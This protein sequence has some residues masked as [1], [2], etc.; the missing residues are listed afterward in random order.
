MPT[1]ILP[2]PEPTAETDWRVPHPTDRFERAVSMVPKNGEW[3]VVS[4]AAGFTVSE[5][6]ARMLNTLPSSN[7]QWGYRVY[8]SGGRLVSDLAVRW[9]TR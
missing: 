1:S 9:V 6:H 4:R 3:H 5:Q 2:R 7:W 8:E